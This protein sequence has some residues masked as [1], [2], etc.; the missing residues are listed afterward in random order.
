MKVFQSLSNVKEEPPYPVLTIGN[1]DGVH[2]GHRHIF[3]HVRKRAVEKCGTSIVYTFQ[4]HPVKV[5]RP[6][7]APAMIS[8]LD[9]KIEIIGRNGID[10]LFTVPFTGGLADLEPAAF[11]QDLKRYLSVRE[12]MVST[13]FYFGKKARGNITLLDDLGEKYGYR[14][15]II[16][17]VMN[18]GAPI[19]SSRIRL[20]VREG[21]IEKANELLGRPYYI[22]GTVV[23]GDARG[24]TLAFPTANLETVNELIPSNGV[25]LTMIEVLGGKRPAVTNIG[26]RPTFS[27]G[28]FSIETHILDFRKDIYGENVRLSF[29][30]FLR[31]E[32]PFR[33]AEALRSQIEADV[34]SARDYFRDHS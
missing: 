18:Q 34:A 11:I 22:D 32:K 5:L 6:E 15:E 10:W 21:R 23:K 2:Q 33:S 19:S 27:T 13:N 4:D 12:I 31:Q 17:P 25:Y 14:L 29:I 9:Q 1:F 7:K 30:R 20:A 24:R 3:N 8:T 16:P 26:N 28:R